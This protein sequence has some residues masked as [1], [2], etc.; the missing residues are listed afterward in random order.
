MAFLAYTVPT[1]VFG[2]T[3]PNF[4]EPQCRYILTKLLNFLYF[5]ERALSFNAGIESSTAKAE[6]RRHRAFMLVFMPNCRSPSG[7]QKGARV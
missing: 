7:G 6:G 4:P 1:T 2:S 5:D 3:C